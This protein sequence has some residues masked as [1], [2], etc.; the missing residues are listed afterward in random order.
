MNWEG[1]LSDVSNWRGSLF[2]L[3]MQMFIPA[4]QPLLTDNKKVLL[5]VDGHASHI[6]LSLTHLA[7]EK[8]IHLYCLP[9]HCTHVLQPLDVGVYGPIKKSWRTILKDH[10][11][12]TMAE[13][14]TKEIF[15]SKC[16]HIYLYAYNFNTYHYYRP[17]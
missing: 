3:L 4:V 14:V 17:Y 7:R 13:N 1:G 9:P 16:H 2:L 8:G 5:F 12:L 10:K 11:A 6:S 15:P